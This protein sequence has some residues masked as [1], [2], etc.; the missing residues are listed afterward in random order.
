MQIVSNI[1][2]ISINETLFIQ[3]ISFLIFLFIINRLMFKPLKQTMLER[4]IY[5]TTLKND[6]SDAEAE[7]E[8]VTGLMKK[9]EK[10]TRKEANRFREKLEAEGSL[11]A[12]DIF[13]QSRKE[14]EAQR[15]KSLQEITAVIEAEK[16]KIE[17]ESETLAVNVMEKILDR[18]LAHEE[19]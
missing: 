12:E 2:L 7:L 4:D 9:K 11:E 16:Q 5:I 10:V 15:V 3:L 19:A 1:A 17:K 13:E 14:I 8:N 18:R 6:I